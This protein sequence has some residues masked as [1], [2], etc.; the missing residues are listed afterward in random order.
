MASLLAASE[1]LSMGFHCAGMSLASGQLVFQPSALIQ[2]WS[3]L[4]V[5]WRRENAAVKI[6]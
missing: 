2:A 6:Q 3:L 1:T 4:S 5:G